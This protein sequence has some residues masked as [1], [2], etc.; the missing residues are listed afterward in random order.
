MRCGMEEGA[1]SGGLRE[2]PCPF[3]IG[4]DAAT[5]ENAE[6]CGDPAR[7]TVSVWLICRSRAPTRARSALERLVRDALRTCTPAGPEEGITE[8]VLAV[9]ISTAGAG[10]VSVPRDQKLTAWVRHLV[11]RAIRCQLGDPTSKVISNSGWDDMAIAALSTARAWCRRRHLGL[12]EAEDLAQEGIVRMLEAGFRGETILNPRAWWWRVFTSMAGDAIRGRADRPFRPA[13]ERSGGIDFEDGEQRHLVPPD[14]D[15]ARREMLDVAPALIGSL[16]PP[17]REIARLQYLAGWSRRDVGAWL[18]GW[19][20]LG[21]EARRKLLRGAHEM[22][23]AIGRGVDPVLVWPGRYDPRK[24]AWHR[25][26]PPVVS[27]S[28]DHASRL[29]IVTDSGQFSTQ[30]VRDDGSCQRWS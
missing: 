25:Y 13:Q 14:E 9:A 28:T 12:Q 16:P 26:P 23:R 21:E 2:G 20:P 1:G 11:R 5:D 4:H 19:H 10:S 27:A 6:R 22:L 24:N 18:N 17:Y 29:P 30:G 8:Q 15:A 3:A 7:C